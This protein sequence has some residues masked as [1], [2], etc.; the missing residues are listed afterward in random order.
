MRQAIEI[1]KTQIG[2]TWPNPTVGC[3]ITDKNNNILSQGV[4][5]KYG[6]PHAEKIAL[7]NLKNPDLAHNLYVTLEPCCYT[8]QLNE[9]T[10]VDSILKSNIKN[11]FIGAKDPNPNIC[12]N[13]IN[14]LKAAG[15]N[16]QT[17][18]CSNEILKL[19]FGFFSKHL[20]KKA[21]MSVKIAT[22]LD[23][24]IALHNGKSKW[25]TCEK[26]RQFVQ[27]IRSQ[28]DAILSTN[29]TIIADNPMLT[30]RIENDN[31]QPVRIAI[32]K[33][34]SL[35]KN[36][37]NTKSLRFFENSDYKNLNCKNI[38]VVHDVENIDKNLYDD[39]DHVDFF[40]VE[41][42]SLDNIFRKLT[43]NFGF[44]NILIECGG[45]FFT[46]MLKENLIDKLYWFHS[47]K[48]IGNDGI[49]AVDSLNYKDFDEKMEKFKVEEVQQF[50]DDVL[51]TFVKKYC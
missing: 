12:G 17:G 51:T 14:Q 6:R 44:N 8:S 10:C 20:R 30:V 41:N 16:V 9:E 34:L 24:K 46:S 29:S 23:G 25:L 50:G 13:G 48:I 38:V 40:Y 37:E 39:F 35:F 27:H 1:A 32:D 7:R 42:F 2:K 21:Q 11:I 36:H 22:S 49:A 33:N 47:N 26:S 28:N 19:N 3:V 43:E 45:K 18:F 31:I 4:T 15:L 5:A